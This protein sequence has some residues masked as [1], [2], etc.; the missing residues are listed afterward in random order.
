MWVGRKTCP[1]WISAAERSACTSS[2]KPSLRSFC[3]SCQSMVLVI[4]SDGDPAAS[5]SR[6]S[7]R[8]APKDRTTTTAASSGLLSS[9]ISSTPSISCTVRR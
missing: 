6:C 5:A 7:I 4:S 8:D 9:R 2:S 1:N 3:R